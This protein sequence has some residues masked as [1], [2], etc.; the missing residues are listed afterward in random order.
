MKDNRLTV[1]VLFGG[2]SGEHEVSF[3]SASAVIKAI[4]KEKYIVIPIGITKNGTWLTSAD[5]ILALQT[6]EVHAHTQKALAWTGEQGQDQLIELNEKES[7]STG[8]MSKIDVVFPVLHGP[9]GEDGTVQGFLELLDI[10][11]VGSGVAASALAMDKDLMKKIFQQSD[12]PQTRWITLKRKHWG[13]EKEKLL[14]GIEKNLQFPVF[15][16]P[17]NL[18]SSVGI[19]KITEV[20][21]LIP[22]IDLASSYDRKIIIEE[23][24]GNALEIE[25]AVLGNDNPDISIAGEIKPNSE[26]YDYYSKYLDKKTRLVIPA[27]I[28]KEVM[29]EVRM[30]AKKA[31][32]AIDGAGMARVDFFVQ[33]NN[34][35]YKVFLNEINT[36]PGFTTT[37]MYPKL[38]EK[39]GI[40]FTE[41]IDRLIILA[42]ERFRE[43][44]LN[45][46][47]Y[48]S[49]IL[50]K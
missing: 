46:T 42:I 26:Y 35:S 19:S 40:G 49:L 32:L 8:L 47:D 11:Y 15:V 27:E 18:G 3:C 4:D 22:A 28:P 36:I 38:W 44:K 9:Y 34:S 48:P 37:S 12:L 21:E 7:V 24:I 43:K 5:S 10:P 31:Y 20:K 1:G 39:S 17:T 25:C 16:K 33:K 29:E 50:K 6:G 41:L 13:K 45:K 2:K 30:I 14:A 23:A